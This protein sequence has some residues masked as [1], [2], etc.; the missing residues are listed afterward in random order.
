MR[1]TDIVMTL[2]GLQIRVCNGK[3]FSYF[4]TEM[5]VVSTQK[6]RLN[7]DGSFEHP[8]QMF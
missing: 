5:Y 2:Q 1:N 7:K 4:S 3:S 6:K 8:K